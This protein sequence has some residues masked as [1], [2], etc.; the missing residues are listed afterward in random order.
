MSFSISEIKTP[1]G[2]LSGGIF[3]QKMPSELTEG[4]FVLLRKALLEILEQISVLLKR[5]DIGV[6]LLNLLG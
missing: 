1:L 4:V 6:I 5:G 2:D 3:A